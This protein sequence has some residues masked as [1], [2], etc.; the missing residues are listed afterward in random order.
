MVQDVPNNDD[1][2]TQSGAGAASG[3][4]GDDSLVS[5][6]PSSSMMS[7]SPRDALISSLRLGK[8]PPSGPKRGFTSS[9]STT[10]AGKVGPLLF[11]CILPSVFC[12]EIGLL[13]SPF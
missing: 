1:M 13:G 4:G 7:M 3:G 6:L 11:F 2:G 9:S 8:T 12:V 10:L 5:L